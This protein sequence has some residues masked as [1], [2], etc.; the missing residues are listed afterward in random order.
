LIVN[1]KNEDLPLCPNMSNELHRLQI[2]LQDAAYNSQAKDENLEFVAD[3]AELKD[4]YEAVSGSPHNGKMF[5][6]R[7]G[8]TIY[9]PVAT[10]YSAGGGSTT[11]TRVN[12]VEAWYFRCF[13]C[14]FTLPAVANSQ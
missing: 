11:S 3:V 6:F 5:L 13:T 2:Q 1:V 9:G 14:G 4:M 7:E 10:T 8:V 12:R